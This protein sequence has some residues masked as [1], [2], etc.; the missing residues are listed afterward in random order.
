NP[1]RY[2]DPLGLFDLEYGGM[3]FNDVQPY[4]NGVGFRTDDGTGVYIS[5]N[6]R[7]RPK[8]KKFKPAKP[9]ETRF[10]RRGAGFYNEKAVAEYKP[11]DIMLLPPWWGCPPPTH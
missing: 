10:Y 7:P 2:T 8:P 6:P 4:Q 1:L 11:Y 9:G 3:H 5:K